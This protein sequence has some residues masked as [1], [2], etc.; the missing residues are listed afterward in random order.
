M[1]TFLTSVCLL[2]VLSGC[3]RKEDAGQAFFLGRQAAIAGEP[4]ISNPY[5]DDQPSAFVKW[6]KGW[7]SAFSSKGLSNGR[8]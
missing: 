3:S 1:R 4:R 8:R 2:A 5:R 6:N 7:D